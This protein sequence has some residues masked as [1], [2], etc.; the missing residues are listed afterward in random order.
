MPLV[1]VLIILVII[2]IFIMVHVSLKLKSFAKILSAEE[3]EIKK[4]DIKKIVDSKS[5]EIVEGLINDE[6][7]IKENKDIAKEYM[8]NIFDSINKQDINMLKLSSK[9]A[10]TKIED[11]IERQKI[12]SQKEYFEDVEILELKCESIERNKGY[13]SIVYNLYI[14]Y[15]H[16]IMNEEKIIYGDVDNKINDKYIISI[17]YILNKAEL[18]EN[19]LE[20]EVVEGEILKLKEYIDKKDNFKKEILIDFIRN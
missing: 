7:I 16:F 17:A 8:L 13:I 2:L 12:L 11:I 9:L 4:E 3:Y 20:I 6:D 14:R 1:Y 5:G 18:E 10:Y 19:T 15:K